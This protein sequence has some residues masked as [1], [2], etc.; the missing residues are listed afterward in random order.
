MIKIQED[1]LTYELNK[2]DYTAKITN[3]S[4]TIE[5]ICIPR[6]IFYESK[7]YIVKSINKNAF[8]NN[9]IVKSIEF[10]ENSELI[11]IDENAFTDSIIEKILLPDSLSELKEGWCQNTPNLANVIISP[12]NKNFQIIDDNNIILGK[13]NI[14]SEVFDIIIFVNRS[15]EKA[16]I[17]NY[18]KRICQYSFS[19]CTNLKSVEFSENS[20]L[21]SIGRNSFMWCKSLQKIEFPNNSKLQFIEKE[22]FLRSSIRTITIPPS[23]TV[24]D[25]G[26][27]SEAS[28]LNNV[29]ISH[30]SKNFGYLADQLLIGKSG[31]ETYDELLFAKR[32]ISTVT[33]PSYI[34]HIR[35]FSF[36]YCSNLESIEFSEGSELV[37]IGE[38]AFSYSSLCSISIPSKVQ[39]LHEGWCKWTSELTCVSISE[40]NSNFRNIEGKM[41]VGKSDT[42]TEVFDLLV[43]ANR[44]IEFAKIPES[45]RRVSSFSFSYCSRLKS[46]EFCSNIES[47]GEY[48]FSC[49]SLREVKIP[50][51]VVKIERNCFMWCKN[52]QKIELNSK[53][54]SIE[55]ETFAFTSLRSII[56][57]CSVKFIG[58]DPF[59]SCNDLKMMEFLGDHLSIEK[60]SCKNLAVLSFP[61]A[62]SVSIN[63][64]TL[65][66]LPVCCSFFFPVGAKICY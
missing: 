55:K 28:R 50:P 65:Y 13:S 21:I 12:S 4:R 7:E 56:V 66:L 62:K 1:G 46:V 8:K 38:G 51:N 42:K 37:S 23:L 20:D 22:A 5:F 58:D 43:F 39:E 19:Y 44:N 59:L 40:A 3:S 48:S 32:D 26:W 60:I 52:L 25:D 30:V 61:N 24:L 9:K 14:E 31:S 54:Q 63:R 47:I 11:S 16:K 41:I 15:I 57:P 53:I 10:V 18:I 6:S 36:S 29:F 27:C 2:I 45:V 35:S 64:Y 49:S 33:I 34:K 17:P